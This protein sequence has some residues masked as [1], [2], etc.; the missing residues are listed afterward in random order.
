LNQ[1]YTEEDEKHKKTL[2]NNLILLPNT[3][4]KKNEQLSLSC[5]SMKINVFNDCSIKN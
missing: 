3:G 2:K 1:I 5:N 4:S